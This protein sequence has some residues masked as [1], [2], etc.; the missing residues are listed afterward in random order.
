[1]SKT[2]EAKISKALL[3]Q[4]STAFASSDH[5]TL[6]FQQI[7]LSKSAKARTPYTSLRSRFT[8]SMMRS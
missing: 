8:A 5:K 6:S 2:K 1:M 3:R 4:A 7:L